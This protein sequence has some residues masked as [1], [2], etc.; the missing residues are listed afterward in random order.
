MGSLSGR[1][2][3]VTGST[4]GIGLGIAVALAA[5]GADVVMNGF[6]S[7]TAIDAAQRDVAAGGAR[8][9]MSRADAREPA[10]IRRMVAQAEAALGPIDILVNNAGVQFTAD[11]VDFPDERWDEIIAINLSAAF[12]GIKAVTPGMKTRGWGRIINIASAHGLVGSARKSAYVAA[13]HG[14]LGLTKVAAIE[15]ANDGI[16]VNAICP[17]W[18]RT[19]LVE[20]QLDDR[21]RSNARSAEEESR[22]LLAEKQPMLA[23]TTPQ[24]IGA[25][26]VFLCSEAARTMTGAPVPVDGGWIAQ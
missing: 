17:G 1:V 8:V 14:L 12:H 10:E 24:Q 6:G 23:F 22:E 9:V 13:K 16:T 2:A 11:I 15:L 5:E 25:V 3:L 20:A 21:A 4:S 18:V 26:A 19:T 7:D